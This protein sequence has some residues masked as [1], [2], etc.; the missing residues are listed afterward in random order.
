MSSLEYYE[1]DFEEQLLR[2]TAQYYQRKAA[3]WIQVGGVGWGWGAGG[4]GGRSVGGR[5]G[6]GA[7]TALAR[8]THAPHRPPPPPKHPPST[9]HARAQEDSTPDHLARAEDTLPLSLHP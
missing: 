4:R 8:C 9:C 2:A 1:R 3:A 7:R 6:Q 5:A